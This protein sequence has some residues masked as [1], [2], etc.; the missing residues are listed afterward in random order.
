MKINNW[1]NTVKHSIG[2]FCTVIYEL[3]K[4]LIGYITFCVYSVSFGID[5]INFISGRRSGIYKGKNDL[6]EKIL[7]PKIR[8]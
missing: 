5:V 3:G 7:F 8:L 4:I 6:C 1:Q 2:E